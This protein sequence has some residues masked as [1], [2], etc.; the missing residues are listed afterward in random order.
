M[1][2]NLA[3][4][5]GLMLIVFIFTGISCSSSLTLQELQSIKLSQVLQDG[6]TSHNGVISDGLDNARFAAITSDNSTVLIVSADDNAL[7]Q[8]EI[9]DNFQLSFKQKIENNSLID[10]LIGASDVV[11][12]KDNQYAYVISFYDS[13]LVVF[14]RN[15]NGLFSFLQV[16]RDDIAINNL[17][18]NDAAVKKSDILK[19]RGA[20]DITLSNDEKHLYIASSVSN[21][22]TI[23]T[24]LPSG[25][26]E[27][28]HSV[29]SDNNKFAVLDNTV[30]VSLSP[31][32][33]ELTSIS[34]AGNAINIFKRNMLG[35]LK[36]HQTITNTQQEYEQLKGPLAV[37]YSPNGNFLYIGLYESNAIMV[38]QKDQTGY[39]KLLQVIKPSNSELETASNF[40]LAGTSSIAIT[41][42]GKTVLT[43][44]EKAH[45][46]NLF[47]RSASGRLAFKSQITNAEVSNGQI[48]NA[49]QGISSLNISA[50]QHHLLVTSGEGDSLMV[51]TIEQ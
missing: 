6:K 1:E 26:V 38:L 51:F 14:K 3:I 30:R 9:D 12:S 23:F 39:F 33:K 29:I 8:Y 42:D 10:G 19:L 43:G 15:P 18:K 35:Q 4:F 24:I 45:R 22:I 7:A 48:K 13:A 49:L 27:Y 2:F 32:N 34:F 17:F 50:D 44:A 37:T 11:I 16:V 36:W 47:S 5:S 28:Y 21:A 31:N 46:I 25:H 41:N 40:N 20:Y